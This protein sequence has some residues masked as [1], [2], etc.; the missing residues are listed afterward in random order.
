MEQKLKAK[1]SEGVELKSEEIKNK[2]DPFFGGGF[3]YKILFL[4]SPF[5][6]AFVLIFILKNKNK[7]KKAQAKGQR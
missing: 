4:L 1:V 6:F 7:N 2:R 3:I 5:A